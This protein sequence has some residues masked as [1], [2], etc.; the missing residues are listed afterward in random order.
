MKIAIAGGTGFVGK[1]LVK[2]LVTD[3]HDVV[4]LTRKAERPHAGRIQY[5]Q[6]LSD[7]SNPSQYLQDIDI[8]VNLA[9]ESI[10]SGRWTE[11]RKERILNS[12]IS[13]VKELMEIMKHLQNKPKAFINA[14]AIGIYGTSEIGVFTEEDQVEGTDFLSDTVKKWEQEAN[15][16]NSLGIRTVLCRFGII[17]DRNEGALP[18]M[19]TPY[20]MYV[21]G[22]IGNGRQWMSWV[23]IQDVIKALLF[24]M[25]NEDLQG[26]VNFTAPKPV[27]MKEFG[28]ALAKVLHKPHWLPVPSFALRLL[29]GEM[30]TLVVEGQKVLPRKLLEHGYRFLYPDLHSALE[31]IFAKN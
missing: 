15:T 22:N 16:A 30:S 12:R 7:D 2:Q 8:F 5:V 13:A 18:K 29:L 1:A 26:P 14:S 27:T 6:W 31:N 3:Q 11:T 23:H 4:I 10:N 20:N 25:E 17:L 19:V 28:P 9:G 24:V 21:G